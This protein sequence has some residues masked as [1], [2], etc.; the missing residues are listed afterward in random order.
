MFYLLYRY[1]LADQKKLYQEFKSKEEL[2]K[3]IE[4]KKDEIEIDKIIK[5]G[6]EFKLNWILKLDEINKPEPQKRGRPRK[7]KAESEKLDQEG[8]EP[9]S[10]PEPELE[11]KEEEPEKEEDLMKRGNN[12]IEAAKKEH[13]DKI[14]KWELCV[15][16]GKNKV[17]SSKSR[18]IC[19]DCL[20]KE[21]KLASSKRKKEILLNYESS[22]KSKEE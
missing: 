5:A 10:E 9:E 20:Q 16:C 19:S 4:K 18:K 14:I 21:K 7:E 8:S 12:A 17:V 11:H 13:E 15:K 6:R 2:I 1:S 22:A 3:F